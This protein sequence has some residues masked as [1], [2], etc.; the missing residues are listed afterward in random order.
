MASKTYVSIREGNAPL[1]LSVNVDGG[2]YHARF[3]PYFT[4]SN[5][6]IQQAIEN[7]AQYGVDVDDA[8]K[9]FIDQEV[10]SEENAADN[11]NT[12]L[13]DEPVNDNQ[14]EPNVVDV[15][16]TVENLEPT[17]DNVDPTVDNVN[18]NGDNVEPTVDDLDSTADNAETG[19]EPTNE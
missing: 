6:E 14:L 13:Q 1:T 3:N 7:D 4:T 5:T 16:P 12:Q 17:V 19:N 11:E 15:E 2:M 10:S 9:T 8:E 18:P